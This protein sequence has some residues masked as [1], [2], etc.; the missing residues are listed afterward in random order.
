MYKR[1]D[2]PI[3]EKWIH[4]CS[5]KTIKKA[6][7]F[8]NRKGLEANF[9]DGDFDAGAIV[10]MDFSNPKYGAILVFVEGEEIT[11][12]TIAHESHHIVD[13]LLKYI[14]MK[15][16]DASDEAYTYLQEYLVKKI[17]ITLKNKGLKIKD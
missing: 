6:N 12:G 8:L 14:G 15:K 3:Y 11:Y 5:F 7:S 2:I 4:L 10:S 17:A 9:K 13:N 16:T 1:I